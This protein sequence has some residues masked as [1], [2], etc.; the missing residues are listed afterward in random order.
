MTHQPLT[1]EQVLHTCKHVIENIDTF[2][3]NLEKYNVNPNVSQHS[4]QRIALG[5]I[6]K[7]LDTNLLIDTGWID[8]DEFYIQITEY[9]V[10]SK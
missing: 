4:V 7:S 2:Y 10:W 3:V 9:I 6:W 8:I 5:G 1:K